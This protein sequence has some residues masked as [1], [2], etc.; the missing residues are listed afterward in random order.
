MH[1][2]R[3]R[4]FKPS[5]PSGHDPQHG[6]TK[7]GLAAPRPPKFLLQSSRIR[8]NPADPGPVLIPTTGEI[9]ITYSG[10]LPQASSR[11]AA[12]SSAVPGASA[13]ARKAFLY[14][15][16][17]IHRIFIFKGRKTSVACLPEKH[18]RR[19]HA[20]RQGPGIDDKDE[21]FRLPI[22]SQLLCIIVF[23][24]AYVTLK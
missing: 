2:I 7:T 16:P 14:L 15:S 6:R 8:A 18:G 11:S 22:V 19:S 10:A 12:S 24:P 17:S 23:F 21:H 20:L 4:C 3:P 1:A 13:P 9:F 5:T